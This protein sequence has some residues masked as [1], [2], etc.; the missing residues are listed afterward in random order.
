[1]SEYH[2]TAC[3]AEKT[4]LHSKVQEIKIFNNGKI[5]FVGVET[6]EPLQLGYHSFISKSM[7]HHSVERGNKVP[8]NR[9]S[10]L[11]SLEGNPKK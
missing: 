5:A 8:N 6:A 1:M 4:I 10:T 11:L 2:Q 7:K 9:V 3:P